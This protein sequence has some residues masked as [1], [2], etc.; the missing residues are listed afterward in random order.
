MKTKNWKTENKTTWGP[1]PWQDESDK[2]QWQDEETEFPCLIVRNPDSGNLCGYVGVS[3][4]HPMFGKNYGSIVS[5]VPESE[6]ERPVHMS[7]DTNPIAL[8][9]NSRNPEGSVSA[10]VLFSCHGG[11]TFSKGCADSEDE[12]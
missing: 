10:D 6:L 7:E 5:G 1:G 3:E 9:C 2:Y 4:G 8:V 11:L 12:S